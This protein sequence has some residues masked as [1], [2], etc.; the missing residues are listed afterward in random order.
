MGRKP[1]AE[2]QKRTYQIMVRFRPHVKD[3]I[4]QTI[5]RWIKASTPPPDPA[6]KPKKITLAD[7]VRSAVWQACQ[8]PKDPREP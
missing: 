3:Q 1:L 4:E 2:G 5:E 7:F 6:K 8:L